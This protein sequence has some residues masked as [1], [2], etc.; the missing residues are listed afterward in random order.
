M[1]LNTINACIDRLLPADMRDLAPGR[2]IDENVSSQSDVERSDTEGGKDRAL[3]LALLAAKKW[4][5][6]RTLRV[7]FLDGDPVLHM[8]VEQYVHVWSQHANIK[9]RFGAD[10]RAEIRIAFQAGGS[11]SRLGNDALQVPQDQPTMNF[12]WLRPGL[13]EKAY[14]AV[15]LHE[16]GHALGCI[17]EHQNP[18][19]GI[20]WNKPAVYHYYASTPNFWSEE[21][22]D[23]NLFRRY[24]QNI[25]KFSVFDRESIMLYPIPKEHTLDGFEVGLNSQLS[26]IDIAFIGTQYPFEQR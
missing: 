14:A 7:R 24:A 5:N 13:D 10:S 26:A 20:R 1:T 4:E 18:A 15:V 16:F 17:H 6:G 8:K 12:G 11:W 21:Q 3:E 22:I 9:F 19:G 2:G 23:A 25:T